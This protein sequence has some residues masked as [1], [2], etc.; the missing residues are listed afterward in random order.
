MRIPV[1]TE[2]W[3]A[4]Q[5]FWDVTPCVL[6]NSYRR[7]GGTYYLHLLSQAVFFLLYL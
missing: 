5:V 6:V 4:V 7:F 2:V 1:L 3:F